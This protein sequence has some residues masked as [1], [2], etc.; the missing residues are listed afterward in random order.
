MSGQ[1]AENSRR[2]EDKIMRKL[3][4]QG[5]AVWMWA[6][7]LLG[8]PAMSFAGGSTCAAATGLVPDGR[9]LSLDY[10]QPGGTVGTASAP[11]PGILTRLRCGTTW[12]ETPVEN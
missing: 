3:A 8:L 10:V 1:Q 11:V 6:F 9:V 12:M 5:K 7:L 2:V 4:M